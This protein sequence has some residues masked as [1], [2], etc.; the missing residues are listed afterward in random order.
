MNAFQFM[1]DNPWQ[2]FFL[3]Y[4]AASLLEIL[5]K[6]PFRA[7]NIR[8]HGWPPIHCDADGD[9]RDPKEDADPPTQ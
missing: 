6:I 4:L 1:A 2:T 8:K 3:A 7:A 5:V 9:P